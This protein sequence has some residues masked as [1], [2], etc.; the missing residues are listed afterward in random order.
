[1]PTT[2]EVL[3]RAKVLLAEGWSEP[4]TLTAAG[5]ICP[6]DSEGAARFCLSDAIALCAGFADPALEAEMLVTMLATGHELRFIE[7]RAWL[8][9]PRRQLADVVSLLGRAELRARALETRR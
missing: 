1:M 5:H 7:F 9:S 8:E 6:P 2:S 3:H 4:F